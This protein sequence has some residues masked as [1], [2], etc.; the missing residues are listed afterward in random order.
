MSDKL[1]TSDKVYDTIKYH[2][3]SD[4]RKATVTYYDSVR[5]ALKT[6]PFHE[7]VPIKAGGEIPWHRVYRFNYN[8]VVMWDR[9]KRF[10]DKSLLDKD[11]SEYSNIPILKYKEK[12]WKED[13]SNKQQKLPKE[14]SLLTFNCLFDIYDSKITNHKKRLPQILKLIEKLNPDIFLLQEITP[15]MKIMIFDN[16]FI[17]DNYFVTGNTPKVHGQHIFSKVKQL[18][19]NLLPVPN[20]PS[21]K[22]LMISLKDFYDETIEV[23]NVHLTS[24][25]QK[26][27]DAKRTSQLEVLGDMISSDKFIVAG[28]FNADGKV[29]INDSKDIWT[30]LRPDDEGFTFDYMN[31]KLTEK[32]S[33]SKLRARIDKILYKNLKPIDILIDAKEPVKGT[34]LSDH[35]C[36][37]SKFSSDF[38][39]ETV[40]QVYD[41]RI[42]VALG[43][44][45]PF[46][47]W[48]LIDA[49]IKLDNDGWPPHI[50]VFQRFIKPDDFRKLKSELKALIPSD[51]K[52]TFD[53]V[54]V[55]SHATSHFVVVTSPDYEQFEKMR[56]K[57]AELTMIKID[58]KP[59]ITL[60]SYD[61]EKKAETVRKQAQEYFSENPIVIDIKNLSYMKKI[62]PQFQV[63]DSIGDFSYS[64]VND[65]L[66]D[67]LSTVSK[68]YDLKLVG[69]RAL[70]LDSNDYDL[71]LVTKDDP[72][73]FKEKLIKHAKFS[74]NFKF[75]E[76]LDQGKVPM[77]NAVINIG[78][79]DID[80][81]ILLEFTH[82]MKIKNP[83]L[84]NMFNVIDYV[85]EIPHYD[86]FV[87]K[88]ELIKVWAGKRKIKSQNMGYLSG[89]SILIL[90]LNYFRTL[91]EKQKKLNF[92]KGFFEYYAKYDWTKPINILNKPF[93]K[94]MPCDDIV[95]I[96]N[97]S[98]PYTNVMRKATK[99]S[100][101]LIKKEFER[102]HKIINKEPKDIVIPRKISK[103]LTKVTIQLN[104]LSIFELFAKKNQIEAD[105]WKL[106]LELKDYHEF[107][108]QIKIS[109][110]SAIIQL[111]VAHLEVDKV[112]NYF[113]KYR[114]CITIK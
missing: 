31:N 62:G 29:T 52:M 67:F 109:D 43:Y 9:E 77:I 7:W 32:L 4:P 23:Y 14:F 34:Y 15:D 65:F 54:E 49:F 26:D 19:Q 44:I 28:D 18:S 99:Y 35:F 12:E 6:I 108:P 21:K 61:T 33:K 102:A 79:Q 37:F 30:E 69:S 68:N 75:V 71:V 103:I 80:L 53:K 5:D 56:E 55:F 107:N 90:T 110:L 22:F 113:K 17:Q 64:S 39:V 100:W 112:C 27:A 63:Y 111:G 42:G 24:A 88:L 57:M 72:S 87:K 48:R 83:Y 47:N 96:I 41:V 106:S 46:S 93:E 38:D 59:H 10:Y 66:T 2:P 94:T 16:K 40:K 81:N 86:D 98:A 91:K 74:A 45:L 114:V 3:N 97:I 13:K 8:N 95:S 84:T 82:N 85:K 60:N 70:G 20:N 101:E 92:L 58:S 11:D 76:L 51:F 78:K 1:E 73:K 105:I 89:I 104:E 36:L 25:H 50:T